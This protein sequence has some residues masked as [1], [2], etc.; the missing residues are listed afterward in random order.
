MTHSEPGC[1]EAPEGFA[2]DGILYAFLFAVA[3]T[4]SP[5]F[6]SNQ[7][8]Y[9]LHGLAWAGLGHLQHDWLANTTDP[10][11]LFSLGVEAAYRLAGLWPLQAL[12]FLLLMGYFLS[13]W[14]LIRGL[15]STPFT[16][17][18]GMVFAT[19]FIASHAALYRWLSVLVFGVDYPWYL[20]SGVAGQYLLGP[21]LQPS[22]FGVLLLTALA[23]FIH[24]RPFLAVACQSLACLIHSTYLL[25]A[26]LLTAGY[27]A[28]L[29]SER[30]Y[31][32]AL[33]VA[34]A[35]FAGILP[36]VGLVLAGFAPTSA[37]L[38]RQAQ[39]ILA[40]VRIPHHTLIRRWLDGIAIG[41]Y[42]WI[43]LGIALAWRHR[44]GP[45]MAVALAF[46]LVLTLLQGLTGDATLALFFPWRVTAVLVP[47]AT[48]IVCWRIATARTLPLPITLG[49]FGSLLGLTVIGGVL[50]L[51]LRIGYAENDA[52]R[53]TLAFVRQAAQAGD[54]YLIPSRYPAVGQGRGIVSATFLPPPRPDPNSSLIP[55]DLQRFRLLTGAPIFVDFKAIPYKDTEVKEWKRRMDLVQQWYGDW[56]RDGVREELLR[57]G[58]THVVTPRGQPIEQPWLE[59]ISK[60]DA[61]IIYRVR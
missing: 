20:Q 8:Q 45:L 32:L 31:L 27:L 28:L 56:G 4:Q 54:V 21:G 6:F 22:A 36:T 49:V 41:Q 24:Q 1:C 39:E 38:F 9:L 29:T 3:H 42:A 46:S 18:Q 17:S 33:A 43:M 2:Y 55:V 15:A 23:A 44:L 16:R 57:E 47:V 30:R 48:A 19:L 25:P 50:I 59:M 12:F 5:L 13:A 35:A 52:E 53:S 61:Y 37:D 58:I 60:D 51:L 34:A 26:G 10:T 14:W 7:N 40:F 11:P